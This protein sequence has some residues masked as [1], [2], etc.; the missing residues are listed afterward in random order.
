MKAQRMIIKIIDIGRWAKI[1]AS[2]F[3]PLPNEWRRT[4]QTVLERDGFRCVYCGDKG[5][6]FEAD[7]V[8]PRSRGGDDSLSN[9]VCACR[10][11]NQQKRD[12]TPEEWMMV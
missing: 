2:C 12:K 7:H 5:G 6:P 9:L 10:R 8:F 11:C 3:P 1:D 4:R